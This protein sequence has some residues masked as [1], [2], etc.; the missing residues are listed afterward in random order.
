VALDRDILPFFG[1]AQLRRLGRGD[2]QQW[3]DQLG[4]RMAPATVRRTYTILDLRL[5]RNCGHTV[6]RLVARWR[7]VR[8][9]WG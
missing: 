8:S 5:P 6:K 9:G 7:L 1:V 3:I 4:A 2:I